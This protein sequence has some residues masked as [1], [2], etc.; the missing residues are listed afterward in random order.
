MRQCAGDPLAHLFRRGAGAAGHGGG[1]HGGPHL[2]HG[3]G[4]PLK[5]F[6]RL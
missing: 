5:A 6:K 1:H 4:G 2:L 3:H